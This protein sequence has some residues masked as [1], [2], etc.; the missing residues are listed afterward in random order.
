MPTTRT[1]VR[2]AKWIAHALLLVQGAC[3]TNWQARSTA[4]PQ[5]ASDA[6]TYLNKVRV[7]TTAG[8]QYELRDPKVVQDSLV[9]YEM[10]PITSPESAPLRHAFALADIQQVLVPVPETEQ[11]IIFGLVTFTLLAL[12]AWFVIGMSQMGD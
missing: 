4:T 8:K 10:V 2:T 12:T 5:E 7:R 11:N 3:F 9:G 6:I 1:A